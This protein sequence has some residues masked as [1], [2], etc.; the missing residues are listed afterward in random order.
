MRKLVLLVTIATVGL[1]AGCR[2]PTP[3]ATPLPTEPPTAT[4]AATPGTVAC[5][6]RP[7]GKVD[8]LPPVSDHDWVRGPA[9]ASITLLEYSDFQ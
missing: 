4:P 9:N 3:T 6:A 5:Y 1:V 2:A 7:F 8:G